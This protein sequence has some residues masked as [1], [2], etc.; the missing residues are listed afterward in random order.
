MGGKERKKWF[1]LPDDTFMPHIQLA[2]DVSY[3]F[4]VDCQATKSC[5]YKANYDQSFQMFCRNPK[6]Q[7]RPKFDDICIYLQQPVNKT[8]LYWSPHDSTL[9][10]SVDTLG[11][12]LERAF[13]LYPELQNKYRK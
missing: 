3:I 6:H 9:S 12:P 11:A 1:P 5:N 10:P 4:V 13:R 2:Y 7:H 8:L